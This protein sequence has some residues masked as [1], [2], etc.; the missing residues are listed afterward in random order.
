MS[1]GMATDFIEEAKHTV[2]IVYTNG[3]PSMFQTSYSAEFWT[4]VVAQATL[5][6]NMKHCRMVMDDTPE[7]QA[8]INGTA[9][10]DV[11]LEY[12]MGLDIGKI[13]Q[14]AVQ[15]GVSGAGKQ[16]PI[17]LK[18]LAAIAD[19]VVPKVNEEVEA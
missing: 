9:P 15:Y 16:K 2:A 17:A 4:Q 3:R 8:I 10:Q 13:R 7:G 18:I 12:L 6:K 1:E 11:S 5:S 14:V 19:G